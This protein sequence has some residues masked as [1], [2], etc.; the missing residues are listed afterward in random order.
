MCIYAFESARS[1]YMHVGALMS[2]LFADVKEADIQPFCVGG[3][4]CKTWVVKWLL[5][6]WLL[7]KGW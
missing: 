3:F 7:C 1:N 6:A 5:A 4:G 2:V